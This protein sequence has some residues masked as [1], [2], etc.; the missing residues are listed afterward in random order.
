[1]TVFRT[2]VVLVC[3][4]ISL[5]GFAQTTKDLQKGLVAYYPFNNNTRD[6]S[7]NNNHGTIIG[8]VVPT[9]DR[10]GNDCSAMDFNGING[11]IR[12]PSSVSLE[13]PERGITIAGWFKLHPGGLYKGIKWATMV[14]KSDWNDENSHSPH[15]RLQVTEVTLSINT[16][17]TEPIKHQI[18]YDKWYFYAMTY[19]GV[20]VQSYLNDVQ[21][22]DF[23]YSN[24]LYTDSQNHPLDIGRDIPGDPE[25]HYGLL[26]DIRIY[27]RALNRSEILALYRDESEKVQKV[28]PCNTGPAT[29]VPQEIVPQQEPEPP[30]TAP[31]ARQTTPQPSTAPPTSN[32]TPPASTDPAPGQTNP[33]IGVPQQDNTNAGPSNTNPSTPGDPSSPENGN[34]S[35]GDNDPAT[36]PPSNQYEGTLPPP[37]VDPDNPIIV[38]GDTV[39]FQKVV[40][41]KGSDL[42]IFLYDH[43]KEDGDIVSINVN[44]VWVVNKHRLKKKN[45]GARGFNMTVQPE[46]ENYLISK[47]W[48]LGRIPPNTLTIEI[49]DGSGNPQVIPIESDIGRSGAIKFI[50]DP[51]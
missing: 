50:Y 21:V 51:D 27:N 9:T 49:R 42:E 28:N 16:D 47:A 37:I 18:D 38:R 23:Y 29:P 31:P 6:A 32:P 45:N 33:N 34:P 17:F 46:T 1:M 2:L 24:S 5:P 10:F 39:D 43:E 12:V 41:V 25:Y 14:C 4:L 40:T 26:D 48:N 44:G 3:T 22:M 13:S 20:R 35:P 36:T 19:D 30:T 8:G 7:G 15:Y 11:Y